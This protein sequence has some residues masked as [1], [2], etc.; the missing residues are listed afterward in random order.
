MATIPPERP[1]LPPA[2]YRQMRSRRKRVVRAR[3][4]SVK[5]MTKRETEIGRILYPEPVLDRPRTRAEC[6]SAPRPCP[7]AGCQY[8]LFLDV[9]PKTGSIKFNFPDLEIWDLAE[10]CALDVAD[11]GGETLEAVGAIVNV[12][13][14]RVR[15]VEV[16][17]LARLEAVQ[18]MWRLAQEDERIPR[19]ARSLPDIHDSDGG[20]SA[21]T[22][23]AEGEL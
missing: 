4:V 7:Y 17:A 3:T 18:D 2:T 1:D 8:H 14:E 16:R 23:D 9:S 11:R 13:R 22:D 10:S 15:Q 5:R 21:D 19:G 6:E 20:V 12:T